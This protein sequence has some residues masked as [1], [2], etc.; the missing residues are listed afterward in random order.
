M[1]YIAF[2]DT[3]EYVNERRSVVLASSNVARYMA[4]VF[5]SFCDVEIISPA[6][7]LA[8]FGFWRGRRIKLSDNITLT[9]PPSLG[10]KTRFTSVGMAIFTQLWLLGKLLLGTKRGETICVYHSLSVIPVIRIVRFLKKLRIILEVREIYNDVHDRKQSSRA[11]ELAF[12]K[13]AD[14]F[15]VASSLLDKLINPQALPSVLAPG[16]YRVEKPRAE[17]FNDGKVHVVYAGTFRAIKG[18]ALAAVRTAEFLPKNYVVHILGR[19]EPEV[20]ENLLGEIDSVSRRSRA[21]I[22]YEGV[23]FGDDFKTF[24]QRC[25]VGLST[26]NPEESF[27]NTSFPSK[28]LTYLVNGLT[29]VS[30]KVAPVMQSPVGKYVHYYENN[31]PSDIARCVIDCSRD[32]DVSTEPIDSVI[33]GLEIDLRKALKKLLVG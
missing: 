25:H 8:D 20:V 28:V 13:V 9:L 33:T 4:K 11:K 31:N 24:L 19:G 6:R 5:S 3:E 26:Q 27:N 30:A 23:K 14:G 18:G 1:K 7:T 2:V 10:G 29:V 32:A 16:I 21:T 12:F 15:I 22:V 17:K